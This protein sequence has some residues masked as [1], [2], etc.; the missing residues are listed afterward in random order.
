VAR[1]KKAVIG[2][3]KEEGTWVGKETGSGRREHD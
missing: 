2:A 1:E 3:V